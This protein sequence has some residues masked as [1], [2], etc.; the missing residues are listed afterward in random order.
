MRPV[1]LFGLLA[2]TYFRPMPAPGAPSDDRHLSR[3][4]GKRRPEEEQRAPA[5]GPFGR[6]GSIRTVAA[7]VAKGQ[8][9]AKITSLAGEFVDAASFCRNE[10]L[11][12]MSV[13]DRE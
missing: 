10:Q 6:Y 8:R 5:N 7:G 9:F 4:I 13:A 12:V 3:Q 1:V 2:L 11:R